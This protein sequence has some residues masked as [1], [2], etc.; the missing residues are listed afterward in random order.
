M[1]TS[2]VLGNGSTLVNI[3]DTLNLKDL[4]WPFVGEANHLSEK[5]NEIFFFIDENIVYLNNE[6]FLIK[7]NYYDNSL[8]STSSA[9]SELYNLEVTFTDLV[10]YDKDIFLRKI[11]IE[12]KYDDYRE[13]KIFFKHNYYM[14]EDD[15]GNT[16]TWY[17]PAKIMCHYKK[18]SYL[19]MGFCSKVHEY[20]CS[21]PNDNNNQGAFPNKNGELPFNPVSTGTTQSCISSLLKISANSSTELEYFIVCGEN[22]DEIS[23]LAR[24]I[25][26]ADRKNL[27]EKTNY[28]WQ[29]WLNPIT[30]IKYFQDE[31]KDKQLETLYTRS[32]LIL[33]TQT[34]NDGAIIAANDSEFVKKGGKDSYSYMWPR[35]GAHSAMAYIESGY[36]ELAKNFFLFCEKVITKEGFLHHKYYSDISKGIGSSW[37][38]WVDKYGNEQLPIQEDETASVVIAL[39]KYY[40]HYED[41]GLITEL[42]NSFIVPALNFLID[43]RFLSNNLTDNHPIGFKLAGTMLPKPSYDIWEIHWG[44]H[45]YTVAVVYSAL[46]AGAKLAESMKYEHLIESCTKACE[47]IKSA[48]ENYFYD[49]KDGTFINSIYCDPQHTRSRYDKSSD[50]SISAL[51]LYGMFDINDERITRTMEQL[52]KELWIN[53]EIGGMA[54]KMDDH[55]LQV[56]KSLPGNPWFISSLWMAQYY[57]ELGEKEKAYKYIEWV[58]N[59]TD[60]T[61]LMAEQAHPHTGF[62]LSMKPLTWSHAEFVRTIGKM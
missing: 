57:L 38:P 26:K 32:L 44:V 48:Y 62:G 9:Y 28:Y 27:E 13:I 34:D 19:G 60:H 36:P 21:S 37:H 18:N 46:K 39:N 29:N 11:K 51:W 24:F 10:L 2:I 14:R 16:A 3:D 42:W 20:T 15:S 35:D 45:S 52:E 12:N 53:T 17:E 43:Y 49:A 5:A 7:A 30:N 54:R 56:D 25:R 58:V 50:I 47:Q 6:N 4:Y 22:Y 41:R 1:S 55:Y 40:Q 61:G 23:D 59:H 8:V 33:R 31:E